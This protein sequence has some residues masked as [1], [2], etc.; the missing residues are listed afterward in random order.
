MT[1]RRSFVFSHFVSFL[2]IT[3][4]CTIVCVGAA[5]ETGFDKSAPII[6]ADHKHRGKYKHKKYKKYKHRKYKH[7][8]YKH[9]HYDDDDYYYDEPYEPE[10]YPVVPPA[11]PLPPLPL[12][13]LPGLRHN[14]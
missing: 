10:P 8:K 5:A 6:L 14:G 3:C 2:I 11:L 7:K 13:P 9:H 4:L 12:P 1:A